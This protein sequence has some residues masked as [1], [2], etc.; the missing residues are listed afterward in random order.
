MQNHSFS[1]RVHAM[2]EDVFRY[3]FRDLHSLLCTPLRCIVHD[4]DLVKAAHR[5]AISLQS[6]KTPTDHNSVSLPLSQNITVL[7][8]RAALQHRSLPQIGRQE[9]VRVRDG[10]ECSFECVLESLGGAG[11]CSVSVLHTC[12]LQKTLD[13]WRS[14]ETCTARRWDQL[15]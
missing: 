5:S 9:S 1:T 12:E 8:Q 13:G 4:F 14:D 3:H 15:V 6:L 7:L 11:R 2:H 10:N